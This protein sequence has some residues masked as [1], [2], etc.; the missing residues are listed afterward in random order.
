MVRNRSPREKFSPVSIQLLSYKNMCR[1]FGGQLSLVCG[2]KI[3]A[4]EGGIQLQPAASI[5]GPDAPG[6]EALGAPGGSLE[7]LL[8]GCVVA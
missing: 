5:A 8:E 4:E 7:A 2:S 1:A 6:A 3:P